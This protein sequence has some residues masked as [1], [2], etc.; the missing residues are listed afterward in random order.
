[1]RIVTDL[2]KMFNQ[3]NLKIMKTRKSSQAVSFILFLTFIAIISTSIGCS[4]ANSGY[5]GNT[6]TTTGGTREANEVWIQS[7]MFNP[8]T[9]TVPVNTTVTWTN[10]DSMAHTV[11]SDAT[12][13]DSHNLP[14]GNTFSFQFTTKGTFAY[15]CNYHASMKGTIVVN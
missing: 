10:K 13:F 15:H 9:L 4:K 12:M 14:A 3:I 7:S 5:Y 11:T 8:T 6:T 1:V 2:M